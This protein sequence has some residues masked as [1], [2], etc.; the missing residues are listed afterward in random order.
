[1]NAVMK[2]CLVSSFALHGAALLVLCSGL[3]HPGRVHL[4]TTYGVEDLG[5]GGGAGGGNGLPARAPAPPPPAEAPRDRTQVEL[6]RLA[7][8]YLGLK[9]PGPRKAGPPREMAVPR[10]AADPSRYLD[11][12]LEILKRMYDDMKDAGYRQNF[13]Y[14]TYR[15]LH[16]M[17]SRGARD[18][19]D[20]RIFK[21]SDIL[22]MLARKAAG[23]R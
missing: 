4:G 16:V 19:G 12:Q 5:N 13:R 7:T 2:R 23:P 6:S 3:F 15:S 18:F 21:Q 17:S 11:T 22:A 8:Q 9:P 10:P 14:I 1:V 20:S